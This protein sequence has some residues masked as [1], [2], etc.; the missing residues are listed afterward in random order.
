[1][2]WYW[3]LYHTL[4]RIMCA[5]IGLKAKVSCGIFMIILAFERLC[6]E[7]NFHKQL[8][9]LGTETG[10][11]SCVLKGPTEVA[12][13]CRLPRA[14]SSA[15]LQV[16]PSSVPCWEIHL[17]ISIPTWKEVDILS[18]LLMLSKICWLILNLIAVKGFSMYCEWTSKA[19]L[20]HLIDYIT[21]NC[22]L[23]LP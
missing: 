21:S 14:E 23:I 2:T 8:L 11:H 22:V 1:M 19:A 12:W 9:L 7:C 3:R 18:Y 4:F 13:I 16:L 5:E 6:I 15:L 17:H 20:I 10:F